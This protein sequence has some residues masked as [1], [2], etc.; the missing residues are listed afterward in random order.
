MES[1]DG[2]M[3]LRTNLRRQL[4]FVIG[5]DEGASGSLDAARGRAQVQIADLSLGGAGLVVPQAELLNG[6]KR[7]RLGLKWPNWSG[8]T[9]VDLVHLRREFGNAPPHVGVRFLGH[10]EPFLQ[11][12]SRYLVHTHSEV[13]GR[14]PLLTRPAD[15]SLCAD[16]RRVLR[17]LRQCCTKRTRMRVY[18]EAGLLVGS[19]YPATLDVECIEGTL[20]LLPGQKVMLHQAYDLTLHS[21]NSLYRLQTTLLRKQALTASFSRPDE[22][23]WG[24]TRSHARIRVG[25][26]FPVWLEFL[27][28]QIPGKIL[29]KLAR[30][31]GFAGLSFGL[32][33]ER[34]MIAAGTVIDSAILR[35]PGGLSL[36]CRGIIRHTFREL[37]GAFA[38][39]VQL[40]DFAGSAHDVWANEILRRLNPDVARASTGDLDDVW[41]VLETSGYLEEKPFKGEAPC[42]RISVAPGHGS[43]TAHRPSV[44]SIAASTGRSVPSPPAHCI[45][46]ATSPTTWPSIVKWV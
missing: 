17:L 34:D 43:S 33:L 39:G 6:S 40:I 31:V 45:R 21:F 23:I 18:D 24:L 4:R 5:A 14:S 46:R 2:D 38:C 19:F 11:A 42:A 13:S 37:S 28:P 9:H 20:D 29:R 26:E 25:T 3:T 35:L 22:M 15:T 30:D 1:A 32:D 16:E 41:N 44:G 8:E 10:D 7:F 36:A 12:L 27:H